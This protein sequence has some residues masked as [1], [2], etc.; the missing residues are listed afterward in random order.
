MLNRKPRDRFRTQQQAT[1]AR[2]ADEA[3]AYP[4]GA[5]AEVVG[6]GNM[7]LRRAYLAGALVAIGVAVALRNSPPTAAQGG[8]KAP[9]YKVDPFWPK[10]LPSTK[11]AAGLSHQW[12]TGEVGASC[13]DS[14]DHIITVNRGFL[15]NSLL[16]QEGAQSIPAPPVIIYDAEGSIVNSWG[17]PALTAAG[18]AAVMPNG[19]H[20]CFAD[21]DDNIWIAGNAD[22]IVQKW[23]HAGKKM[24][25]QIAPKG[26][27]E[28]PPTA[29]P[30]AP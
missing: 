10:P 19:I 26:V 20:G 30:Q 8:R 6:R 2:E 17:D 4:A 15:K 11:D 23:S 27:C 3:R 12:V 24:L 1:L 22:G 21:Y 14:H 5:D 18:A 9:T 16:A 13:I 25:L 29:R 7:R 28:G